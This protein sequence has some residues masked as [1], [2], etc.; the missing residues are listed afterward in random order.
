MIN[1]DFSCTSESV[2][3]Y[4]TQRRKLM[5]PHPFPEEISFGHKKISQ[6][7]REEDCSEKGDN[8]NNEESIDEACEYTD[9]KYTAPGTDR[10]IASIVSDA[11]DHNSFQETSFVHDWLTFSLE[12]RDGRRLRQ[13][14]GMEIRA[15]A[16][17]ADLA[18]SWNIEDRRIRFESFCIHA[19]MLESTA[20]R[21]IE[22]KRYE[23]EIHNMT[24]ENNEALDIRFSRHERR[25]M[26]VAFC[27]SLRFNNLVLELRNMRALMREEI[28]S[29]PLSD[30]YME[31][32]FLK[33]EDSLAAHARMNRKNS[34]IIIQSFIRMHNYRKILQLSRCSA[35]RIQA[36]YRAHV[37]RKSFIRQFGGLPRYIVDLKRQEY[38]RVVLEQRRNLYFELN[39]SLEDLSEFDLAFF[40][41]AA[42]D[43]LGDECVFLSLEFVLELQRISSGA[44][45]VSE[46]DLKMDKDPGRFQEIVPARNNSHRAQHHGKKRRN[47]ILRNCSWK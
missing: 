35:Q 46:H 17:E 20:Y 47:H 37:S 28:D 11:A 40:D 41:S 30:S 33:R 21:L 27:D 38:R 9:V 8:Y 6:E 23:A 24:S 22:N 1:E 14:H 45:I 31:V 43:L 42:L 18:S 15:L 32:E 5:L 36:S 7:V 44:E 16:M 10:T 19:A 4:L 12:D 39:E 26:S 34:V 3:E 2:N 29:K 25:S 13:L